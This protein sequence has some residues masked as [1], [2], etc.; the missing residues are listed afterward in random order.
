MTKL[1]TFLFSITVFFSNAQDLLGIWQDHIPQSTI[2][3]IVK[4]DNQVFCATDIGLFVYDEDDLSITTYSKLNGLSD[5]GIRALAYD[6]KRAQ[7]IMGYKNGNIDIFDG[8]NITNL[9]DIVRSSK[10]VGKKRVNHIKIFGDVAYLS[11]GFGIIELDLDKFVVLNTLIIGD[12]SKEIEVFE[13]DIDEAT[14][15]I[16]AATEKAL[17]FADLNKPLI[18]FSFWNNISGL[19]NGIYNQVDVFGNYI[20]TNRESS[21]KEDTVYFYDGNQ[22][23]VF[24]DQLSAK[25]TDIRVSDGNL[26]IVNT[27]STTIYNQQLAKVMIIGSSFYPPGTYLPKVAWAEGNGKKAFVGNFTYGLIRVVNISENRRIIPDGPFSSQA[28]RLSAKNNIVYVAP[29]SIDEIWNSKFF[30]DG[31]FTYSGF[32]WK[33]IPKEDI[34]NYNDIVAVTQ[35]PKNPNKIWA[36]AWGTGVLEIEDGLLINTWDNV[37]TNGALK[38]ATGSGESDIRSGGLVFDEKGNMWV[39]NSLTETPLVVRYK[40]GTWANFGFGSLSSGSVAFKDILINELGQIWMQ[41]RINGIVVAEVENGNVV[42]RAVKSGVGKGNLPEDQVL[43]M[44]EDLDGE[45]WIGTLQGLVVLYSPQNI[46]TNKDFDAQP[47]LFEEDGVVQRLLGTEQVTAI[48][49]DGANKKWFGTQNSGVFY[50]SEDGTETIYH[51][52]ADNSPLLSNGILSIAIDNESGE[53]FFGTAEGIVSFRGAATTGNDFFTNVYAYPNPVR[54]EHNGPIFIRGLATNA[55]VK[56]T[57]VQGNIVYETVAEGGQAI[58]YGTNLAGDKVAS[59]VYVA[60]LN[61]DDGTLKAVT[62][63]LIIR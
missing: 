33:H 59:G 12:N 21:S 3:D 61:N 62:K 13:T 48:A 15:T 10:F 26:T 28:Y 47:V 58:W 27:F 43:S 6:H 19:S 34:G 11:T 39:T 37:T 29:G 9:N 38:G 20:F 30:G 46:F 41:T 1:F 35:D 50:T 31:I 36:N 45:I 4:V 22:W 57:D 51:F 17:M 56:I 42:S 63:I 7:L 18:F 24:A 49:I 54:P 53:V 52:T 32:E 60:Y 2:Y 23:Q 16:Y 55:Q 5:I 40:D 8:E 14:E 44:A 25:K